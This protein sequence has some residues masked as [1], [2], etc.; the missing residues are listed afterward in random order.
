M[1]PTMRTLTFAFL[2]GASAPAL[3]QA[4][5]PVLTPDP[6]PVDDRD[7]DGVTDSGDACPDVAE[8]R[9]GHDDADG[10]PEHGAR[11]RDE[12]VEVL[13]PILFAV[14]KATLM[15]E[16]RLSLKMAA[17]MLGKHREIRLIEVQC[18]TDARG[19]DAWNL[20][21]SQQRAD[22]VRA[23]L[24][25]AGLK[26]ARVRARGYGET[27][28]IDSNATEAG[29]ARNRRVELRIITRRR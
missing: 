3:A 17:R 24:V 26:P 18:H 1:L 14:G 15:P 25:A 13:D 19:N 10:C 2:L 28:P 23:E 20:T 8:D 21:L 9:D 4:Q 11:L 22:A 5:P 29:R 27:M 6:P 16:S 12:D 7:A